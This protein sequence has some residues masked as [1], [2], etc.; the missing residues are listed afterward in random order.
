MT[1]HHPLCVEELNNRRPTFH[2]EIGTIHRGAVLH[3]QGVPPTAILERIQRDIPCSMFDVYAFVH[4]TRRSHPIHKIRKGHP[5]LIMTHACWGFC[6]VLRQRALKQ[7]KAHVLLGMLR[8]NRVDTDASVR[9]PQWRSSVVGVA[10]LS[11]ITD[12]VRGRCM[13]ANVCFTV[14]LPTIVA[15]AWSW[16]T[17]YGRSSTWS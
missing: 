5:L 8:A 16:E 10:A 6:S 14:W 15:S 3:L 13:G 11:F 2:L 1:K 12:H 17:I 4:I 9:Q 7:M